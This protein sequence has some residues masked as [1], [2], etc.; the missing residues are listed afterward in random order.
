VSLLEADSEL[1]A[2]IPSPDRDLAGSHLVAPVLRIPV[3]GG[4]A[5]PPGRQ[6]LAYIVLR[7]VASRGKA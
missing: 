7:A 6:P 4:P 3:G 5:D 2:R 1:A